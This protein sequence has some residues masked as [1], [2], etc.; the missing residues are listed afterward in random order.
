MA[1]RALTAMGRRGSYARRAA[2]PST[3]WRNWRQVLANQNA[4]AVWQY[5][6][7]IVRNTEIDTSKHTDLTQEVFLNLLASGRLEV[8]FEETWPDERIDADI[9]RMATG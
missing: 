5:I 7:E 9:L 3:Q 2:E 8:Y 6:L 1:T 4:G